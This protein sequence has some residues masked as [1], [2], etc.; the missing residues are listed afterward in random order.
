L[1][2]DN[3]KV[4]YEEEE[5]LLDYR[6]GIISKAEYEQRLKELKKTYS[7]RPISLEDFYE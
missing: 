6:D 5:L 7:K 1:T 2:R 4:N 3:K